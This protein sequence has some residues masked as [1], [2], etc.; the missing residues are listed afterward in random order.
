MRWVTGVDADIMKS[1]IRRSHYDLRI[2]RNTLDG[3]DKKAIPMLVGDKRM[4]KAVPASTV[5]DPQF[6]LYAERTAPQFFSDLPPI[7]ADRHL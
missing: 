4:A 3:Y 5:V 7:P 6:Y 1:A 2:S